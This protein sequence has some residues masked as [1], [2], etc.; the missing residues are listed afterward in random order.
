M[1]VGVAQLWR[2]YAIMLESLFH[3]TIMYL[4]EA[5]AANKTEKAKTN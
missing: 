4:C 1:D 2:K 3:V 5:R